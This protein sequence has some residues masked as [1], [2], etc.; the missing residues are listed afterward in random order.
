MTSQA[1]VGAYGLR[2]SGLPGAEAALMPAEPGWPHVAVEITVDP[3][4]ASTL[5]HD[6]ADRDRARAR[7][8]T[9]GR[10]DLEREPGRAVFTV[11][12]PLSAEELVHPFLAPVAALVSSWHGREA[13]HG[14]GLALEGAAWGVLAD[15]EAG[16][17]SLLAAL[18][19]R[20][21]SVVSDD[22]LVIGQNEVFAGPRVIDLREEAAARLGAGKDIGIAGARERWRL[23]LA[24]LGGRLSLAGWVFPVWAEETA[25][26]RIQASEAIELL[27]RNRA[28]RLPPRDPAAFLQL[29]ALPAWELRRPRSWEALPGTLDRLLEALGAV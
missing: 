29:S 17:S 10:I 2:L 14:G 20:D 6:Y 24:P 18:A 15:R 5:V 27:L 28:T 9:G 22:V 26:L 11:P 16:K 19:A 3:D 1:P 21:V 13:F 7:L 25:V 4:A 8:R 23:P 12:K